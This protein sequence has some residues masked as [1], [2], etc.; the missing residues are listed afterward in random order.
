M[1]DACR[2]VGF[3][4]RVIQQ[5]LQKPTVLA[6]G[7]AARR[8]QAAWR[9]FEYAGFPRRSSSYEQSTFVYRSVH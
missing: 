6:L 4:P 1:I 3:T 5:A 9:W 2:A 7:R 8:E